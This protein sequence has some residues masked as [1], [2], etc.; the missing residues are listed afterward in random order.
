MG[1]A[2]RKQGIEWEE[3]GSGKMNRNVE[4]R[5]RTL[6]WELSSS[7]SSGISPFLVVEKYLESFLL[8]SLN[9][10]VLFVVSPCSSSSSS[11]SLPC[12]SNTETKNVK[13][14]GLTNLFWLR[15][16]QPRRER[17]RFSPTLKPALR[18]SPVQLNPLAIQT[19]KGILFFIGKHFRFMDLSISPISPHISHE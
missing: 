15:Q 17:C 5:R 9:L 13:N 11:S 10:L 7:L 19:K 14:A 6:Y 2:T 16:N 3:K 4:M 18:P 12:E 8:I 1:S